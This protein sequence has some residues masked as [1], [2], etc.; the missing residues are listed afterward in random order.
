[1]N[2]AYLLAHILE[3]LVAFLF[4]NSVYI[5]KRKKVLIFSAG[6]LMYAAVFLFY[7]KFNLTVVN[8]ITGVLFNFLFGWPFYNIKIKDGIFSSLFLTAAL[9]A[10]EFVAMNVISLYSH[11]DINAFKSSLQS[12]VMLIL[13]SRTLYLII[14]LSVSALLPRNNSRRLPFFLFLFPLASTVVLYTLWIASTQVAQTKSL[15]Y[16]IMFSSFSLVVSIMLTYVFYSKTTNEINELYKTQSE[17]RIIAID[18]AYYAIL[19]K[20]NKELKTILHDEKNHLIAIK[21]LANSPEVSDYIDKVYGKIAENSVFGSTDNKMLDLTINKYKYICDD[22]KIDFYVSVKTVNFS[23]IDNPDLI[24]LLGN[25]LDN[26][27][28]AASTSKERKVS[29]VLNKV[30]G[31]D[32]LTCVNSCENKPRLIGNELES[33]K[34]ASGFHGMG[35]KSIKQIVK[36]YNGNFE[37]S[38]DDMNKEFTVVTAF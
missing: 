10:S 12:F 17:N 3:F 36:K 13:F 11:G 27:I 20:Q 38:Y 26:A 16:L 35:I 15:S 18:T 28:E 24:T 8:I 4:F 2:Y 21:S 37:W 6:L 29:F 22:K 30:N 32:V 23:Y 25:I 5:P 7:I 9:T 19:D 1:M 14:A 33:T 34:K 31:F